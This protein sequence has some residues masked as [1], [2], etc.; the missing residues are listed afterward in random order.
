MWAIGRELTPAERPKLATALRWAVVVNACAAWLAT[1]FR[2]PALLATV[3][4]RSYGLVGNPVQLGGLMAAAV[5]LLGDRAVTHRWWL[6]AVALAGGA[7]QLSGSRQGLLLL[8]AA[9][10]YI[11][12]RHRRAAVLVV[13][14]TIAGIALATPLVG[15]GGTTRLGA[16]EQAGD[17]E[18]LD[19][20]RVGLAATIDHPLL[21]SGPGLFEDA[22]TPYREP[23]WSGCAFLRFG[24]AHNLLVQQAVTA[25]LIG[26]GL[27]GAFVF[28]ALRRA[29][30]AL[31]VFG[32]L[33]A[34]TSLLQ[35]SHLGL[36]SIAFLFIG[37]S[38]AVSTARPWRRPARTVAAVGAAFGAILGVL[39][40]RAD[41]ELKTSTELG[42]N[43]AAALARADQWLPP[44]WEVARQ[45][46]LATVI[47]DGPAA[48]AWSREAVR[49]DSHSAL[50]MMQLGQMERRYGSQDA[51]WSAFERSLQLDPS[52]RAG[53]AA[54]QEMALDSGRAVPVAADRVLEATS[55]CAPIG[56]VP[57]GS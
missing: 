18:R 17:S 9:L 47:D 49:R 32:V 45:G 41:V 28:G 53:A 19:T 38:P 11:G 48:L 51:A 22:T 3:E 7:V 39:F 24:D 43:A 27:F 8:A 57:V 26:L 31:G 35:P 46:T 42:P 52:L 6:V 2:V 36:T 20:W 33:L 40:V 23:G 5:V 12:W 56:Q 13:L 25:G 29:R 16:T 55:S 14:A 10:G 15:A 44:W 50:A 34:A 1:E 54:L 4:G 30:S 21:G 37:M